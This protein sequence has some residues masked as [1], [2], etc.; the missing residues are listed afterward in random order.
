MTEKWVSTL[1]GSSSDEIILAEEEAVISRGVGIIQEAESDLDVGK[2]SEGNLVL[3]NRRLVYVHGAEKEVELP[4]GTFSK[5]RLYVSD[6]EEL[7]SIPW[8]ASNITIPLS[9]IITVKGHHTPGLA[10]KLEVRWNDG[11]EKKTEFVEQET[12]SSRRKNLNNWAPGIE[13]LKSGEQKI[14]MLPPPPARESLEG[15]VLLVLD[16]M[17]EKGL[18]TIQ[19][20]VETKSGSDLET[21]AV[22]AACEALVAQGF[23]KRTTKS[24]EAPFYVKVSALGQD[25]LNQ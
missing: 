17:Q 24:S 7:D 5:K 15:K 25:D 9:S 4:V 18:L 11:V 6:V 12:G 20:E 23:V 21:D 1:S 2:Q 19:G 8:D 3:T 16:D 13:R 14:T 22:E 10:P